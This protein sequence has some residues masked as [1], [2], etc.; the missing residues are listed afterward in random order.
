MDEYVKQRIIREVDNL[1]DECEN[2][3]D[4]KQYIEDSVD[5]IMDEFPHED[6]DAVEAEILKELEI[7]FR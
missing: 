7:V 4:A 2:L 3:E 5:E 6:R 1:H